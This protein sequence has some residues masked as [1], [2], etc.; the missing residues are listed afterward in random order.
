M[1]SPAV[2]CHSSSTTSPCGRASAVFNGAVALGLAC[3]VRVM[4]VARVAVSVGVTVTVGETVTVVGGALE[5]AVAAIGALKPGVGLRDDTKAQLAAVSPTPRA[6][7][8][9]GQPMCP[10][11]LNADPCLNFGHARGPETR[12]GRLAHFSLC[13][14]RCRSSPSTR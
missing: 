3:G 12:Q 14:R 10:F 8:A 2:S 6:N 9:I 11:S 4:V 1:R 7:A 5:V 13:H